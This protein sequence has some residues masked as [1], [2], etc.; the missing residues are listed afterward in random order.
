MRGGSIDPRILDIGT[1]WRSVVTSL[2]GIRALNT[3]WIGGWVGPRTSPNDPSAVQLLASCYSDCT[4]VFTGL[5][6]EASKYW[7]FPQKWVQASWFLHKRIW[8]FVKDTVPYMFSSVRVVFRLL[9]WTIGAWRG[10]FHSLCFLLQNLWVMPK[11][12][13]NTSIKFVSFNSQQ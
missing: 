12:L 10:A 6:P 1:S 7:I 9:D 11:K 5:I 8:S 3:H 13:V 4:Q 2:P